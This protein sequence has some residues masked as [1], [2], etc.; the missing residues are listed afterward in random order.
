[1][2]RETVPTNVKNSVTNLLNRIRLLTMQDLRNLENNNGV[3]YLEKLLPNDAVSLKM[4][5]KK[6]KLKFLAP[7]SKEQE[8]VEGFEIRD[9]LLV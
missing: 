6:M 2:S 5:F 8:K 3:S 7:F 1:M 4:Y 9:F